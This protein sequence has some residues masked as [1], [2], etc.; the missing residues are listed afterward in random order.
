[1][2]KPNFAA[3]F[4]VR[5]A[6]AW[7]ALVA[8]A[9]APA[10][11]TAQAPPQST[12]QAEVPAPAATPVPAPVPAAADT[13]AILAAMPKVT[14]AALL[15]RLGR[16]DPSLLLLDVRNA[17]EYAAGHVPGARNLPQDQLAGRLAELHV[18]RE[19]GQQIVVYCRSG[20]RAAL[21]LQTLRGAG[22]AKIA[23][24]EGDYLAWEAAGLAVARAGA[25]TPTTPA[26]P[27]EPGTH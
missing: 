12:P 23:H 8:C 24:L 22:F 21:A 15:E 3:S 25:V 7:L 14:A 4:P 2:L 11:V 26:A 13:A 9:L 6:S 16:P 17:E 20:R 18:A 10:C 27:P 1:M 19:A 5:H